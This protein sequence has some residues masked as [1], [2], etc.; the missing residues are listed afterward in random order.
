MTSQEGVTAK[1]NV[2]NRSRDVYFSVEGRD[3]ARN[4]HDRAVRLAGLTF[5]KSQIITGIYECLCFLYKMFQLTGIQISSLFFAEER[6]RIVLRHAD[7]IQD[8]VLIVT[9]FVTSTIIK[10]NNRS[11]LILQASLVIFLAKSKPAKNKTINFIFKTGNFVPKPGIVW[12][13]A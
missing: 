2:E 4:D 9:V 6:K 7:L 10:I 5:L 8:Q 1:E 11:F 13:Q 3:V 12:K